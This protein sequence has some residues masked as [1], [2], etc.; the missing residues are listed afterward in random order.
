[1]NSFQ[2]ILSA[3]MIGLGLGA[4]YCRY[5][6]LVWD[7]WLESQ[8][9]YDDWNKNDYLKLINQVSSK[10]DCDIFCLEEITKK[11]NNIHDGNFFYQFH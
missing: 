4:Y 2:I 3:M 1:M 10:P 5:K 6:Y 7:S 8:R 11:A 9:K